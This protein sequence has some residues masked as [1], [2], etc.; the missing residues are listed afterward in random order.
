ME[1]ASKIFHSVV[2]SGLKPCIIT[3]NSLIDGYSKKGDVDEAW[4]LFLE[5]PCKGLEHTVATYTS[6][7]HG[8]F[9]AGEIDA[10]WKLFHEMEVHQVIPGVLRQKIKKSFLAVF[11]PANPV[12]GEFKNIV[13]IRKH[14]SVY[15]VLEN[16]DKEEEAPIIMYKLI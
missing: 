7:L 16:S 15:H 14:L 12:P 8:L 13:H 10:G 1:K 5:A 4:R 11:L 3:Y 2:E 9:C 6:M